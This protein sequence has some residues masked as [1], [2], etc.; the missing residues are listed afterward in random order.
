MARSIRSIRRY[1]LASLIMAL[2]GGVLLVAMFTYFHAAGEIDELYDKNMSEVANTIQN[3]LDSAIPGTGVPAPEENVSGNADI[4]AEEEFLIQIWD[5]DG[6][7][8]YSSHPRIPFPLQSARGMLLTRFDG[9]AWR[10]YGVEARQ[11]IIQLSQPQKARVRFVR[12]MAM[13]LLYPLLLLVPV[14]GLFIWFAVGRSLSPFSDVSLA[15]TQRSANSLE[16]IPEQTVPLEI[17]PMVAELNMLLTRLSVSLQ[18]QRSFT[19]DAAHELRTPLTALQ[20][21]LDN[22]KR[23]KNDAERQ[24]GMKTLQEGITR[25]THVVQQLLKLARVEPESAEQAVSEIDLA[26]LANEAIRQHAE[27]AMHKQIDLGSS[28]AE[29]C[30]IRGNVEHLRVLLECLL[31]NALNYTPRGGRVD[32]RCAT[33]DGQGV[34]SIADNGR[35]VPEAERTRIFERFYRVLG[36]GVE[37]T[38]LGL[39]IVK[40]IV[41]Q[42]GG[43]I[44]V[45]EG[46]DGKG[47]AFVVRLPLSHPHGPEDAL[48]AVDAG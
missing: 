11:Y 8:V 31:I 44:S 47:V 48:P 40:N 9:Q 36:T 46:L 32:V 28:L 45:G 21:Q 41:E 6:H 43:S 20:L 10:S 17:R 23:A 29:R 14:A 2:T 39:S 1:L 19:A 18:V 22:L 33:A 12:E 7:A 4:K 35:G 25:G 24:Y 3:Q 37:G 15:I 42:H 26:Q 13:N 30:I 38:G 34:L 27:L 16:P 5:K